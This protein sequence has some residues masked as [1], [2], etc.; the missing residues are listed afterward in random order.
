MTTTSAQQKTTASTTSYPYSP[1]L[2]GVPA[3]KTT[4]SYLDVDNEKI[5]IRGYDLIELAQRFRYIE[6]AYLLLHQELP[7]Q[8]QAQT[9][10][11]QL[12][13]AE[14]LPAQLYE[15]LRFLP[16]QM[17]VM[18]AQRTLLSY[19]AGFEK[20]EVLMDH[21]PE[22][23]YEKGIRI[24]ARFPA[25]TAYA[26]RELHNLPLPDPHPSL[27]FTANFLYLITGE[28][29]DE[30]LARIF[31]ITMTCY[32]EHEMPN[33]TFTARVIASTLSDIYGALVGAVA[34]LKGPLHG[35]ANEA[36]AHMLL[37]VLE[38]GG[39]KAAKNYVLEKLKRKER[40][41]GFGHRVYMR[42]YDPRAALL[43]EFIPKL[44]N[45]HPHGQELYEIYQIIEET[46][47]KEKGLYPNM[48][49]PVGLLYYLMGIPIPLYT[50]IFL[51]ARTAGL[52]AHVIEQH[53][54]NRLFRPRVLYE[55]PQYQPLNNN[56][57]Q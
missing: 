53:S 2:E 21:S 6:V 24:L 35:G 45:R 41:M 39:H 13:T 48:D 30:E 27:S 10:E 50:P 34:S 32:I 14:K 16:R 31:D 40:I 29:P 43:K 9:F 52:I 4:I 47:R 28:E 51:V 1:G 5:L 8:Q 25:I 57:H 17:H 23:N 7:S 22:A 38:Q 26:Y 15:V 36:V 55:G 12:R 20:P 46:M 49:Y 11:N 42:K 19:L 56:T 3:V 33:S 37:E 54:A 44:V 18:D